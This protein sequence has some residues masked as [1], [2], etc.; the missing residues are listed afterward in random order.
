V[1][2]SLGAFTLTGVPIGTYAIKAMAMGY[3]AHEIDSVVVASNQIT[4]VN[5]HVHVFDQGSVSGAPALEDTCEI[6]A[7]KMDRV[8]V[9]ASY[10]LQEVDQE[11]ENARARNFPHAEPANCETVIRGKVSHWA[12]SCST[13]LDRRN[14]WLG[15]HGWNIDIDSPDLPLEWERYLNGP[16]MQFRGPPGVRTSHYSRG[17][18]ETARWKIGDFI[19]DV[20]YGPRNGAFYIWAN[21]SAQY[22]ITEVI[23]RAFVEIS[24]AVDTV[25]AIPYVVTAVYWAVPQ[26]NMA[27]AISVRVVG[28]AEVSDAVSIIQSAR[29]Y[30]TEWSN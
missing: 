27:A 16:R 28:E 6:H 4:E 3:R 22:S 7:K 5:F 17:C 12:S 25:G 10:G 20:F 30:G 26:R 14:K 2:D 24:V 8:V 15:D 18:T 19:V 13:C 11:F 21:H 1:T 29:F 9:P 23:D